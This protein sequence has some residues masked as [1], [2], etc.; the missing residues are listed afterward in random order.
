MERVNLCIRRAVKHDIKRPVQT[1]FEFLHGTIGSPS[2]E[3]TNAYNVNLLGLDLSKW[4]GGPNG[5]QRNGMPL[6][7]VGRE[8]SGERDYRAYVKMHIARLCPWHHWDD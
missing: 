1:I 2:T 7:K 4:G 3:A 8:N 6:E 5:M